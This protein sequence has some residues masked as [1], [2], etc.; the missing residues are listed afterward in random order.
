MAAKAFPAMR[1]YITPFSASLFS[2]SVIS[3]K[4]PLVRALSVCPID[5]TKEA[6]SDR[7]RV[8]QDK[9]MA[10]DAQGCAAP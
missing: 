9:S 10:V 3:S 1:C 4:R 5:A 2:S 6:H 7:A 8:L